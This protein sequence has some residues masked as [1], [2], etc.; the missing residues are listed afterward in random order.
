MN[1]DVES[2]QRLR[3]RVISCELCPRLRAYCQQ[4]ALVKRRA[5]LDEDYW[6]KPLPGFG[7]PC[8]RLLIIGLA[9]AA[10]GG[11]RTGRMFT[12]NCS[13][14]WLVR[15]LHKFGF[16]SKDSSQSRD[17]GL[18]LKDAYLTATVR[19][20][21]PG[22]RP[23]R[24]EIEN[25]LRF[26]DEELRLLPNLRVVLT[27]GR[28]A[29]EAYVGRMQPARGVHRPVFRHGAKYDLGVGKPLVV[30]SYHP[31]R[32]NTQTR[33]L[34]WEAWESVLAEIREV[35]DRASVRTPSQDE[36]RYG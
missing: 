19:C 6:G 35:L 26:L 34:T 18:T 22:N 33:K 1:P 32:Q 9:P 5:Y 8:A 14:D 15:A 24:K 29:F 20:A 23:D 3:E 27:L 25:C 13:G 12:G 21:P 4:I 17:D 36:S 16:A 7:D 2:F 28:V 30:A 11:N 10:H 31:S